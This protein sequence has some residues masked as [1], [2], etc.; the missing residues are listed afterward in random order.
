MPEKVNAPVVNEP[1]TDPLV[2]AVRKAY[3]S[4]KRCELDKLL[5]EESR[6]KRKATIAQNKLADVRNRINQFAAEAVEVK[7]EKS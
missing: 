7:P 4:S 3:L 1:K 5:A 6:W 2:R